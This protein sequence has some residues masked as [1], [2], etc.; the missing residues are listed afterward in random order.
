MLRADRLADL[1]ELDRDECLRLLATEPVGRVA[2]A[3][4]DGSVLVVPV[5]FAVDGDTIVFRTGIGT[6]L[7]LL[8]GRR[9]AFE[10][11]HVDAAHRTGWS[12]LVQGT[13][14][15]AT[16][17]EVDHVHVHPWVRGKRPQHVRIVAEEVSG[18]RLVWH[19]PAGCLTDFL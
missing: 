18:R 10:V 13:A 12:V 8:R 2:V 7:A 17:W 4:P 14:Y 1:E 9:A 5:N 11:D 3:R 15:E 19:E 6:K 16:H